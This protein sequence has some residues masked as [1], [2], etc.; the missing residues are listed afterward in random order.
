MD[1]TTHAHG[2]SERNDTRWKWAVAG[3]LAVA[4]F[5]LWT[6]HGAHLMGAL[7]Y[8]LILACPLMHLLHHRGHGHGCHQPGAADS[9]DGNQRQLPKPGEQS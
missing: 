8:L 7:P 9:P 5:F 3:F 2:K 4:A 6:E 1:H